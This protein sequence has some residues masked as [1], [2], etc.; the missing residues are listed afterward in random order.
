[1]TQG[2]RE[3]GCTTTD[4]WN[5]HGTKVQRMVVSYTSV[6]NRMAQVFRE[7]GYPTPVS[8]NIP[9]SFFY[10]CTDLLLL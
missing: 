9:F 2:F 5:Y 8:C 3:W 10:S 1:M 4:F 7:W 6:G